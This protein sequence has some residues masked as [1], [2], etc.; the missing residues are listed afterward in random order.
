MY[1]SRLKLKTPGTWRRHNIIVAKWREDGTEAWESGGLEDVRLAP[2]QIETLVLG[3]VE[4]TESMAGK[5]FDVKFV[6]Y[7]TETE[8]VLDEKEI[9]RA[10]FVK[11][12]VVL[13]TIYGCWIE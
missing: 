8:S 13:G 12:I 4:C 7:D 6:L 1:I 3:G 11:E 2:M 10:W 9:D 5:Y